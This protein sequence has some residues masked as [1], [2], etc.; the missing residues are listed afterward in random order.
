MNNNSTLRRIE[1]AEKFFDF[2]EEK[3]NWLSDYLIRISSQNNSKN[4]LFN[5]CVFDHFGY[6][7]IDSE[8]YQTLIN[9]LLQSKKVAEI[10]RATVNEREISVIKL[11][12]KIPSHFFEGLQYFEICDQKPDGSQVPGFD[13]AELVYMKNQN[14]FHKTNTYRFFEKAKLLIKEPKLRTGYTYPLNQII[15]QGGFKVLIS[16]GEFLWDVACKE[17]PEGLV[18]LEK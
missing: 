13:H 6:R 4:S 15:L 7:C 16:K 17:S 1:T 18:D 11:Q 2:Y 8:H 10:H 3:I 14:G 12:K 5:D 9:N